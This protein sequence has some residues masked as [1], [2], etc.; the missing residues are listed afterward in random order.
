MKAKYIFLVGIIVVGAVMVG[1]S[2]WTQQ[3]SY[4]PYQWHHNWRFHGIGMFLVWGLIL[5]AVVFGVDAIQDRSKS[6]DSLEMLRE[7]Y[8]RGDIDRET[9][10]NMKR[11]LEE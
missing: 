11:T 9:Y 5:F 1:L 3:T 7:R 4:T 2:I 10:L 8:A 6:L